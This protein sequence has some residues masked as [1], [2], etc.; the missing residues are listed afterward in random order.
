MKILITG[1]AGFIGYHIA[2]SLLSNQSNTVTGI[3]NFNS[4]TYDSSLKYDRI[5]QLGFTD[6]DINPFQNVNFY[7]QH[8][9][10]NPNIEVYYADVSNKPT[11]EYVFN[12]S[13][14]QFDTIIHL[15]A[16]PNPRL[17]SRYYDT[18]VQ[19]NIIGTYNLLDAVRLYSPHAHVIIASSSSVYDPHSLYA[20]TKQTSESIA[21]F[22]AKTHGLKITCI[23]PFTVYGPYGRPDMFIHKCITAILKQ[24]SLEL[25][26]YGNNYR[27]F[28]YIDDLVRCVNSII[29]RPP[30]SKNGFT[31]F[32]IGTSNPVRIEELVNIIADVLNTKYNYIEHCPPHP[33]DVEKT[34]ANMESFI[35]RYGYKPSTKIEEGI[36][37]YIDWYRDYFKI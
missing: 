19:T 18:V 10:F 20:I 7:N 28:T 30:E 35:N 15:A 13:H 9:I 12:Q 8:R 32:D 4:I 36:E 34:C 37:R 14:S 17:P 22:Y 16:I 33:Y 27:D 6:Y 5:K 2:K 25:Y 24:V 29:D 26:N 1:I 11:I 3:D 31:V 21:E 23:R